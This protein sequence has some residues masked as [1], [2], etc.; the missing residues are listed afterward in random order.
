MIA[1]SSKFADDPQL[2]LRKIKIRKKEAN[3]QCL[4][5]LRNSMN[6]KINL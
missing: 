4:E 2:Y 6:A 3:L 1:I 5:A